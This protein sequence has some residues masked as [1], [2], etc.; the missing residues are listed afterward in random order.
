MYIYIYIFFIYLKIYT[1]LS[2]FWGGN[3]SWP[4]EAT[5]QHS[6]TSKGQFRQKPLTHP[7]RVHQSTQAFHVLTSFGFSWGRVFGGR[8]E[9][10]K[11]WSTK[12]YSHCSIPVFNQIWE[13][14][15]NMWTDDYK[16]QRKIIIPF[17]VSSLQMGFGIAYH[18]WK[19]E[20]VLLGLGDF[21]W[22][23]RVCIVRQSQ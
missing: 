20:A 23:W 21:T 8:I 4:P 1:Y 3:I 6:T 7:T 9:K 15:N 19:E 2:N 16:C 11:N 22:R 18:A 13:M 12:I 14:Q 17:C 10:S 5:I